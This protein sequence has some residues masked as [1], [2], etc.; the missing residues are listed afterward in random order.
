MKWKPLP[1]P[2]QC[3]ANLDEDKN[4]SFFTPL[5]SRMTTLNRFGKPLCIIKT[6]SSDDNDVL[7][8]GNSPTPSTKPWR[9]FSL[10]DCRRIY[11]DLTGQ[12]HRSNATTHRPSKSRSLPPICLEANAEGLRSPGG[13]SSRYSLYESF[14]DLSECDFPRQRQ[15]RQ[16]TSLLQLGSPANTFAEKCNDW[17]EHLARKAEDQEQFAPQS[18]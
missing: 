8:C 16:Q 17:L 1:F 4:R 5:D 2:S 7:I 14:V 3:D 15:Q 6:S 11:K 9:T 10:P 13:S 12:I 18:S